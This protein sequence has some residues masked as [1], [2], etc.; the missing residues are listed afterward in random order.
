MDSKHG[1]KEL[2]WYK[3]SCLVDIIDKLAIPQRDV[4]LAIWKGWS[5]KNVDWNEIQYGSHK[6]QVTQDVLSSIRW[7]GLSLGY[8]WRITEERSYRDL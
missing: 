7:N 3:G 6:E 1:V 4:I 8:R 2:D 5:S